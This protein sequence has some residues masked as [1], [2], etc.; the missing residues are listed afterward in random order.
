MTET[1]KRIRWVA[2]SLV[3]VAVWCHAFDL[4]PSGPIFHLAGAT[5]W[6]YTGIKTKEGPILLNFAPQIFIWS[7]GLIWYFFL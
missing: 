2:A 5:L 7:S 6:V 3:F 4:Y 1:I